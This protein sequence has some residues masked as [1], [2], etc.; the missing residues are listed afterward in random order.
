MSISHEKKMPT[1]VDED[2][3]VDEPIGTLEPVAYFNGAM[4]TGV[5][6][7]QE[8]RIFINFPKWGDEVLFTVGE[9]GNGSEEFSLPALIIVDWLVEY[10]YL[11]VVTAIVAYPI[12]VM[13]RKV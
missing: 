8:G 3:P 12:N 1:V 10:S 6:I 4:P 5:T 7:S 13:K 2:L 11:L 9:I